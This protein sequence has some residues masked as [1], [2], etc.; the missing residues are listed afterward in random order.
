M[1]GYG[2]SL[3]R[4]KGSVIAFGLFLLALA[5][6]A[7]IQAAPVQVATNVLR[8]GTI[9]SPAVDDSSGI[10]ASRAYLGAFW[11]H[12]DSDEYLFG[13]TKKG[14]TLSAHRIAGVRFLDWE[15][16]A[17]DGVGNV[18]LADIGDENV[19]RPTRV[20]YRVKEPNPYRSSTLNIQRRYLLTFPGI[21]A[22]CESFF[23]TG[24]NGYLVTKDRDFNDQVTIYRFPLAS[25]AA[26]NVLKEVVRVN[27]ASDVTAADLSRDRRR[28]ALLT[29]EGAYCFFIN[30]NVASAG[31]ARSVFTP[32]VNDFVEGACFANKGL[33]VSAQTRELFLFT[34]PAF[35]SW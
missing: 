9:R 24:G 5:S 13:I 11:T 1:V 18:Y 20:V 10:V 16:I 3:R 17:M 25:T 21:P 7:R 12:N 26:T 23:I 35:R 8:I 19:Y 15:D 6:A 29:D 14:A 31:T 34:H 32:F 30:R 28:L 2:N 4:M 27:V 22:D 33:L